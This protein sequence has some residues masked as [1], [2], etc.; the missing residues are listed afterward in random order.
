MDRAFLIDQL[1]REQRS[2]PWHG[3]SMALIEPQQAHGERTGDISI[4][5]RRPG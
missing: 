5:A 4:S 2:D 1:E 3:P